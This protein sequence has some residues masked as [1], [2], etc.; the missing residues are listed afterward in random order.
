[1]IFNWYNGVI[2]ATEPYVGR[3]HL[4][5]Y[6]LPGYG[7]ATINLTSIRESDA[8]WYECKVIFPNRDPS[9]RNNGTWIY[10]TVN[11]K[12]LS[13]KGIEEQ[14]CVKQIQR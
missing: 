14:T 12:R 7:K 6:P 1:M 3:V 2:T 10:L 13:R 8:G 11:G 5:H 4:L 9:S